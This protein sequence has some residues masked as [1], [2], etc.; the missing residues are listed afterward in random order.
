MSSNKIYNKCSTLSFM[1]INSDRFYCN[2][3]EN[4]VDPDN[5]NCNRINIDCEYYSDLDIQSTQA[6]DVGLSM[7]HLFCWR[8]RANL[9]KLYDF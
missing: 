8:L 5:K 2:D 9:N 6:K 4:N 7:T 1:R 3:F